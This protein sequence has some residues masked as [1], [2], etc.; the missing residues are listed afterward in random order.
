MDDCAK[1]G[2]APCA[3]SL[4][5]LWCSSHGALTTVATSNFASV[6]GRIGD[7]DDGC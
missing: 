5:V 6:E 1:R 3:V 4:E 2:N 7:D